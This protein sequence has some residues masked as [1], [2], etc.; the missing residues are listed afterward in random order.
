MR[1]QVLN[2]GLQILAYIDATLVG[3][4]N[5]EGDERLAPWVARMHDLEADCG[6]FADRGAAMDAIVEAVYGCGLVRA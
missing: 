4:V 1:L 2:D 5:Y 3:S 6:S